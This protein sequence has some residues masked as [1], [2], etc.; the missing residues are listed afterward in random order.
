MTGRSCDLPIAPRE[1]ETLHD[2]ENFVGL[3]G[4]G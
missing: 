1:N 4:L 2:V 3:A